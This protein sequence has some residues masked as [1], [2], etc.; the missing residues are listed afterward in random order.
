VAL[1]GHVRESRAE[2]R[3]LRAF[4]APLRP[5]FSEPV[6]SLRDP[7]PAVSQWYGMLRRGA[8]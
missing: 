8:R 4:A 7:R 3:S 5:P 2:G 1:A 6:F